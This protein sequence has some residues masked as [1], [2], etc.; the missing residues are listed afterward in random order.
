MT[1]RHEQP[2]YPLDFFAGEAEEL[3][4]G[5]ADIA[6]GT[7]ADEVNSQADLLQPEGRFALRIY[8]LA[9]AAAVE[10]DLDHLDRGIS[11]ELNM[12]FV[13]GLEH[14]ARAR[15]EP[16]MVPIMEETDKDW[17]G[18]FDTL[19]DRAHPVPGVELPEGTPDGDP[20]A[21]LV[22]LQEGRYCFIDLPLEA[23]PAG[24]QQPTL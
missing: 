24:R 6:L 12:V 2:S 18:Y 10:V 17:Q 3:I 19:Q 14:S 11:G 4:R 8:R 20:L 1:Q 7:A 21:L 13:S 23:Q 22:Y 9:V 16:V 5:Y 15:R